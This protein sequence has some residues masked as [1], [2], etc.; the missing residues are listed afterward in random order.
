MHWTEI[1]E[2]HSGDIAIVDLAGDLT[3]GNEKRVL[4]MVTRVLHAG[5]LKILLNLAGV[6]YVDSPG[7]GEIASGYTTAV[8]LGGTLKLCNV[9]RRLLD[10]LETTRLI[11]VI[12]VFESEEVAIASFSAR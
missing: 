4:D 7:L 5:R 1:T 3:P 9:S 12:E 8:R 6:A 11:G 2:R 10:L